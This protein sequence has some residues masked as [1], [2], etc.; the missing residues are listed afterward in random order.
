M[1]KT[2]FG[3]H[4]NHHSSAINQDG[5]GGKAK[6]PKEKRTS[7]GKG[8]SLATSTPIPESRGGKKP[9]STSLPSFSGDGIVD[10]DVA[11]LDA[12]IA[13]IEAKHLQEM[14]EKEELKKRR[15]VVRDEKLA[16]AFQQDLKFGDDEAEQANYNA[17]LEADAE[18]FKA[19]R[20]S[21]SIATDLLAT[22]SSLVA[23]KPT[24]EPAKRKKKKKRVISLE[25]YSLRRKADQPPEKTLEVPKLTIRKA[26]FRPE[27]A[28]R[29]GDE[30]GA[31]EEEATEKGKKKQPLSKKL[32][33][34]RERSRR[35]GF[36][37]DESSEVSMK[38][39]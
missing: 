9:T 38:L 33:R 36:E 24:D 8:K 27:V 23:E 26:H 31:E 21:S 11:A 39:L 5:G 15:Q 30:S 18:V 35:P 1:K 7:S 34:I 14:K 37:S 2:A 25:E 16:I 28:A 22:S 17:V 10:Q 6:T 29:V 32:M 19:Q 12:R 4:D 13:D 20:Q 3:C